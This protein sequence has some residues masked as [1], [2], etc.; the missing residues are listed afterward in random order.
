MTDTSLIR[1]KLSE[2]ENNIQTLDRLR[3]YSLTDLQNDREKAWSIEHGLQLSIQIIIDT[4]N[5]IL[6][7]K[8]EQ[9]V[10]EYL[11]YEEGIA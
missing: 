7:A 3:S 10:E 9:E 6:A 4:G 11:V 5:H 2:L 1:K 8:G